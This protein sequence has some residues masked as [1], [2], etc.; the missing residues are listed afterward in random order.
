MQLVGVE[1]ENFQASADVEAVCH[2]LLFMAH[3]ILGGVL[4]SNLCGEINHWCTLRRDSAAVC[5][6][7]CLSGP[8][9]GGQ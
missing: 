3:F 5:G 1:L 7:L 9:D 4:N 6:Q 2:E 8:G